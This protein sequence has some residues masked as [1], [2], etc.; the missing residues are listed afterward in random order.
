MRKES[1][2][3]VLAILT[4]L[5]FSC[6][7]N[8][9]NVVSYE[10]QA[11]DLP[12]VAN[13]RQLGGYRIGNKTIKKDILLRSG[14]LAAASDE[15]VQTLERQYSLCRVF[16]FRSR[17]EQ[18]AAPDREVPGAS[19]ILLPC[20]DKQIA[21]LAKSGSYTKGATAEDL[22]AK[23]LEG[24]SNPA[25]R[26]MALGMYPTIVSDTIVQK[27][28]A[29]FLDSLAVLPE[30]RA[31]LWHCAQGKDRCGWATA[32]LL[33]ALGADRQLIVDDFA[34]S[35]NG[36]QALIDK[37]IAAARKKG[38]GQEEFNV[39]YGAIGVSVESFESTLDMIIAQYG[40]LDNYLEQALDCDPQQRE[41]LRNKF[42]E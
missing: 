13:A 26:R 11:I 38:Y 33:A 23:V 24:A 28:Y 27:N 1:K 15:A 12:G 20:L 4:V 16:D 17:I 18:G 29:A 6:K 39:I 36:Y 42:L 40:C 22:A 37:T 5:L 41:A 8:Q 3:L 25:I 34:L 30:G 31:A 35:N 2:I 32:F 14:N 19:E 21:Q 10:N 9:Q 7:G